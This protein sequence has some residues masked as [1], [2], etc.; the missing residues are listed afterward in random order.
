MNVC[1]VDEPIHAVVVFL[2]PEFCVCVG[3]GGVVCLAT[4][5]HGSSQPGIES[6]PQLRPNYS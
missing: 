1:S 2:P 3:A 6:E 4:V 5:A